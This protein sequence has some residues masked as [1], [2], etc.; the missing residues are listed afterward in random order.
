MVIQR[1]QSVLL[2]LATV[3]LVIF[4]FCSLGQIQGAKQTVGVF[5]YGIF[6]YPQH[7]E[8]VGSIYVTIVAM[9]AAVLSLIA[10]F[11]FKNT[12]LQKRIC[13]FVLVLT[14]AAACS[15]WLVIQGLDIPGETSVGYSSIAFTP[16]VALLAV[17]GAYRCI[18]A[19]ERKLAAADRLR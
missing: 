19:D 4:S 2:L 9:L 1:W 15:E 14:I 16:F 12:R 7:V 10:I 11:M 8:L 13:L 6:T 3:M 5:S 17:I 18:R